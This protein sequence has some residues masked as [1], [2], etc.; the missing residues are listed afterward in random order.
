MGD[1]KQIDFSTVKAQTD[2]F[3]SKSKLYWENVNYQRQDAAIVVSV[4][5]GIDSLHDCNYVMYQNTNF[6]KKWFY[7]FITRKEWVSENA[8]RLYLKTDVYQTWM[9]EMKF[10]QCYVL[11]ETVNDD[12]LFKHTIPESIP[13]GGLKATNNRLI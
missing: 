11:R 2:Y 5:G 7:A 9:F 8:A 3:L 12:S 6:T 13:F 10:G 4:T 1:R